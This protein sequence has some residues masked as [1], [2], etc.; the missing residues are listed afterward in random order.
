MKELLKKLCDAHGASGYEDNVA[1]IIKNEL[2]KYSDEVVKDRL[3]NVIAKKGSGN[4]VIMIA[5]HMDEIGFVVKHIDKKGY[6]W[7]ITIGGFYEPAIFGTRIVIHTEKGN[8]I[9]VVGSRPP[10]LMEE[11]E[12][13]RP[14]KKKELYID[15][16]AKNKEDAE[17]LG[18]KIGDSITFDQEMKFLPNGFVTGKAIDDRAGC[19]ALIELM[20]HLD[21][22]KGTVYAVATVQEEVGLKG[23]K[24]SAFKIKPEVG[25]VLDTGL[26]GGCPGIK[27]QETDAKSGKGPV[28]TYIEA[29]G[30]GL[31]AD[32]L[33]NKWLIKVAEENNIPVQLEVMDS[34]MTDGAIMNITG[35][36]IPT[37]SISIP[38][39]NIHS[40]VEICN[41]RDIENAVKLVV[42]AIKKGVPF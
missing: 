35:E 18:I 5:A 27:E 19:V 30:R 39:K 9:G 41:I 13:K 1:E 33:L 16:G 15:V 38:S 31:I 36:G 17:A 29:G 10:H 11:E 26:A 21:E 20:K 24:V 23:A 14:I 22:F 25:I 40:P 7:F 42:Y 28:I 2:S 3:G 37:T 32:P 4:P 6:I 34:G 12:R 8:V